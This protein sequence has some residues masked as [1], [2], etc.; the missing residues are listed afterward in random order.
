MRSFRALKVRGLS[1]P[2]LSLSFSFMESPHAR[3]SPASRFCAPFYVIRTFSLY[4]HVYAR[5]ALC[6]GYM[7]PHPLLLGCRSAVYRTCFYR[8]PRLCVRTFLRFFRV[9][10]L[11]HRALPFSGSATRPRRVYPARF[12]ACLSRRARSPFALPHRGRPH[13]LMWLARATKSYLLYV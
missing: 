8:L 3:Y 9:K 5:I 12:T 11:P 13:P 2:P 4:F 1:A 7:L 10:S 6:R